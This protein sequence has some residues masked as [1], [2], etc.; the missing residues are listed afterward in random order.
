MASTPDAD[1]DDSRPNDETGTTAAGDEELRDTSWSAKLE[2]PRHADDRDLVVAEALAA[3]EHTADGVRVNLVTHGEHGH[4]ETYLY[5]ELDDRFGDA[6]DWEFVD[7][8]GC[9]G[10]VTRVD[11]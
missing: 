7:R 2:G 5:P 6:V 8:C 10:Y 9:G 3:V 1:T 11:A 4:P